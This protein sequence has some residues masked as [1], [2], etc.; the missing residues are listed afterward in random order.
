M[1]DTLHAAGSNLCVNVLCMRARACVGEIKTL[2]L[3]SESSSYKTEKSRKVLDEAERKPLFDGPHCSGD[4]LEPPIGSMKTLCCPIFLLNGSVRNC[5][6][7]CNAFSSQRVVGPGRCVVNSR[8]QMSP[9][10][11]LKTLS[12]WSSEASGSTS[13]PP[14]QQAGVFVTSGNSGHS[15]EINGD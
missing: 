4:T 14:E 13:L 11:A 1:P 3:K 6:S 10:G 5:G 15:P 9:P 8:S 7:E 2:L 12:G